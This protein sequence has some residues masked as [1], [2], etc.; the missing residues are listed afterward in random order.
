MR[1][2]KCISN[3]NTNL[4]T[5]TAEKERIYVDAMLL[6]VSCVCVYVEATITVWLFRFYITL[7]EWLNERRLK[8]F[9]GELL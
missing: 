5:I 6:T 1:E 8:D 3:I 2:V 7:H 4:Q 9:G